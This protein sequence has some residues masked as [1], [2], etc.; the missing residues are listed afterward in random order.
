MLSR[1]R[2]S[3]AG[4]NVSDPSTPGQESGTSRNAG[5][6]QRESEI[7]EEDQ[8]GRQ[9]GY[10]KAMGAGQLFAPPEPPRV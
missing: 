4:T 7:D 9:Q 8:Q 2:T 10:G 3:T 1:R 6:G 5:H